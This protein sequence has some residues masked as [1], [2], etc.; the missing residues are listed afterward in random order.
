MFLDYLDF[1]F[2]RSFQAIK[3]YVA[4]SS[5]IITVKSSFKN[6]FLRSEVVAGFVYKCQNLLRFTN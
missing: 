5:A 4:K 2:V 6:K 1:S 3:Y